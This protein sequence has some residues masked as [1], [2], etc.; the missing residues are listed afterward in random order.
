MAGS[1]VS[2]LGKTGIRW[3]LLCV[4]AFLPAFSQNVLTLQQFEERDAP[5]YLPAHLQEKVVIRGVTS[6]PAFHFPG[7]TILGIQDEHGGAVLYV[8]EADTRLEE[9]R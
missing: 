6:G 4:L 1:A 5:D 8:A 9:F 7:Y 2:G 3:G